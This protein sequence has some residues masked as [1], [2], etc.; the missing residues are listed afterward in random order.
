MLDHQVRLAMRL[1]K[2]VECMSREEY[3]KIWLYVEKEERV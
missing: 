2:K 1:R 3:E